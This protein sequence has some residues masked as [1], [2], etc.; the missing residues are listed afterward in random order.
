MEEIGKYAVQLAGLLLNFGSM[1]TAGWVA[2]AVFAVATAVG[3]F[4]LARWAKQKRI[5]EA[6][7]ETDRQRSAANSGTAE[8]G[9]AVER[10][11]G[12]AADEIDRISR[13]GAK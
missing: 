8:E 4:F 1:G 7:A 13:G 12:A 5:E 10:D 9:R 2:A 3:G 6:N 11:A